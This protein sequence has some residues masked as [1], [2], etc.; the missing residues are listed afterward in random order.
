MLFKN[1]P[2]ELNPR[3]LLYEDMKEAMQEYCKSLKN[4][5]RHLEHDVDSGSPYSQMLLQEVEVHRHRYF[6][7][8]MQY[9]IHY[10]DVVGYQ[11][12]L[13]NFFKWRKETNT[14][15][16]FQQPHDQFTLMSS[17]DSQLPMKG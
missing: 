3:H 4:Y 15:C 2:Q 9:E 16:L 12:K 13:L 6:N 5:Y 11:S 7:L 1:K 17:L 8:R 10:G 14:K